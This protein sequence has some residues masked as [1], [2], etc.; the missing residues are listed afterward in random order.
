[1]CPY[2]NRP[3]SS[4]SPS[5]PPPKRGRGTFVWGEGDLGSAAFFEARGDEAEGTFGAFRHR[6]VLPAQAD[7]H[8]Q[9]LH[10]VEVAALR[11][12]PERQTRLLDLLLRLRK[13]G[14]RAPGDA[15]EQGRHHLAEPDQIVP[16]I[17]R[18]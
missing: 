1:P 15:L 12:K 6:P 16:A 11:Q 14:R 10:R 13:H 5:S 18:G 9:I 17:R 7:E 8:L 3:R 2:A 4:P